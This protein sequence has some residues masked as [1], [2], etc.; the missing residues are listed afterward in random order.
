MAAASWLGVHEWLQFPESP[1]RPPKLEM[2]HWD[3]RVSTLCPC[4]SPPENIL[5]YAW[6][7]FRAGQGTGDC[8]R[9]SLGN[10]DGAH[11]SRGIILRCVLHVSEPSR[12]PQKVC[13]HLLMEITCLLSHLCW[14]SSLPYLIFSLLHGGLLG[15]PPKWTVALRSLSLVGF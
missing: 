7:S 1:P 13:I 15:P 9:S 10:N 5:W 8:P 11:P 3:L 2:N 6:T 4:D 12:S 14:L